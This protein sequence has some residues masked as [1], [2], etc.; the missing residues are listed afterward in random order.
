MNMQHMST[1]E[2]ATDW[3]T[4][5]MADLLA[6][7][8]GDLAADLAIDLPSRFATLLKLL[9][10]VIDNPQARSRERL[11]AARMLKTCLASLQRVLE[12]RQTS[13]ELRKDLVEV[14]RVYRRS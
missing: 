6:S 9:V 8:P 11:R 13:P 14:L 7:L 4:D 3:V 1:R 10:D 2:L 5:P 12:W